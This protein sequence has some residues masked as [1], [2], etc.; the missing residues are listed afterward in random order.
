MEAETEAED[1]V[2]FHSWT[3]LF[4]AVRAEEVLEEE[5]LVAEALE[6]ASEEAALAVA[7]EA[8]VSEAVEPVAD[9]DRPD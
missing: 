6:E 1:Q 5:V 8:E 2:D 7:S 4:L 3:P 9:G